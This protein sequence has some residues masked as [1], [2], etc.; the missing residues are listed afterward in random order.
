[1]ITD[2]ARRRMGWSKGKIFTRFERACEVCGKLFSTVPTS[3]KQ[4]CCSNACRVK[5]LRQWPKEQSCQKCGQAFLARR[6]GQRFCSRSHSTRTR[7]V[8]IRELRPELLAKAGNACERCGWSE[9][10]QVLEVH[11]SNGRAKDNSSHNLIVV[12]PNCHESDHFASRTGRHR[13]RKGT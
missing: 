5:R 12:C 10:P 6:R 8:T 3:K 2:D 7:K 4:F 13:H 9:V 11:H 1:M